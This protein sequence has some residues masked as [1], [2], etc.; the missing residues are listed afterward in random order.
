VIRAG[1]SVGVLVVALDEIGALDDE[2]VVLLARMAE[3]L[4]F[5]L[6]NKYG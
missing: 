3:N 2:T 1:V 5:G 4:S 6:D